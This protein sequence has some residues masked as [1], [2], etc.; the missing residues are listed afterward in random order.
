M[1][2][3]EYN[4][5]RSCAILQF[6]HKFSL[7]YKSMM[8]PHFTLI[9]SHQ[10]T[11]HAIVTFG[12]TNANSTCTLTWL[13]LSLSLSFSLFILGTAGIEVGEKGSGGE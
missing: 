10:S 2:L 13:S 7:F 11:C 4:V 6:P 12:P 5:L 3:S 1:S 9:L 8:S